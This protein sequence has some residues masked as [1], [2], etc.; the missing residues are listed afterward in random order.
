MTALR[1]WFA[2]TFHSKLFFSAWNYDAIIGYPLD[3]IKAMYSTLSREVEVAN[4][5]KNA[6][7][8]GYFL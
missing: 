2:W 5:L 1:L 7:N 4:I 3:S 8:L 6:A